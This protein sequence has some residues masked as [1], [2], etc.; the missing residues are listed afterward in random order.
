MRKLLFVCCTLIQIQLLAQPT[1][2]FYGIS[3]TTGLSSGS[4][5]AIVQDTTGFIW[6]GTKNGLNRYDG[7]R[8]VH[9]HSSNS[10]LKSN[11]ISALLNDHKGRLWVG[12]NGGGL[13]LSDSESQPLRPYLSGNPASSIGENIL[14]LYQHQPD[15]LWVISELGL[16]KIVIDGRS[17]QTKQILDNAQ[18]LN[19]ITSTD[20]GY[21]IGGNRGQILHYGLD[22]KN[23][24]SYIISEKS[25]SRN[26]VFKIIKLNDH[27]LLVGTEHDGLLVFD[28]PKKQFIKTE[29]QSTIV[30]DIL[31]DNDDVLWVATDGNGLYSG[32][33]INEFIQHKH[34][35]GTQ[36]SLI[37][38]AV[39]NLFEDRSNNLWIGTAWDGLSVIDTE[40]KQFGF[41][42]SD[43]VGAK[44][45][46]VLS[47]FTDNKN[48]ILGS[49]G[50]GITDLHVKL[51]SK[52]PSDAYVQKIKKMDDGFFWI[53]TFKNG[54]Y[55]INK[56]S[57][58][59]YHADQAGSKISHND[60][61]D[62]L[63]LT[64][65]TY[66]VATWGGGLNIFDLSINTFSTL[67]EWNQASLNPL[68]IVTME[69]DDTVIWI[70]TYGGGLYKFD[71]KSYRLESVLS[72]PKNIISL[73]AVDDKLWIGTWGKGL[74]RMDKDSDKLTQIESSDL[75]SHETVVSIVSG[76]NQSI[77]I[78]T[79]KGVFNIQSNLAINRLDQLNGE[80]HINA[81]ASNDQIFFGNTKGAVSFNESILESE[82]NEIETQL[83]DVKLFN[84]SVLNRSEL[85]S[86]EGLAL[87]HDQN[88][89]TFEYAALLY[90]TSSKLEYQ[91]KLAPT[92][93]EWIDVGQQRSTTIA[94]LNAGEYTF[95]V[96]SKVNPLSE[97]NLPF[98]IEKPWW[99]KWWTFAI[100]LILFTFFL[101]LFQRYTS[102]WE[103]LKGN[104]KIEKLT[105]EKELEIGKIKQQFFINISHEIRTPLTLIIGELELLAA[106]TTKD[107]SIVDVLNKVRSNA[108]HMTQLVNELL[109]F[110]KLD[111]EGLKLNV[112]EGNIVKFAKEVFLSFQ[113]KALSSGIAYD[114]VVSNEEIVLFFDRDQSEKILFNLLSNA[115]KYTPSGGEI[116][117]T[118]EENDKY[119]FIKIMDSGKGIPPEQLSSVFDRF[120][121]SENAQKKDGFGIGLSI[122]KDIVLLHGGEIELESE[123]GKGSE[124]TVKLQKGHGHFKSEYILSDFQDSE[125]LDQYG[126]NVLKEATV[127]INKEENLI[128]IVEDN[129]GIRE[130]IGKSLE[131]EFQV[132]LAGNGQEALDLIKKELPDII[133]TDVMMPVMDGV[134]FLTKVKS[135]RNTS[136]IPVIMLTARTGLIYK[137][138]GFDLGADDYITKPFNSL[139]LKTRVRNILKN[140]QR[141]TDRIRNEFFINPK[142]ISISSPDE[143]FLFDLTQIV[144]KELSNS[145][146][147]AEFISKELGMSHSVVYKKLKALTG[148][149]IVEFVR[150]YRLTQA[151]K[152][153]LEY[154]CSVAETA[155]KVGFSDRKYFSQIFKKKYFVT[156][157]EYAKGQKET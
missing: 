104:L 43:F 30:R 22:F 32:T 156:P 12:T 55:R 85:W 101:Y 66:L 126:E 24:E 48:L 146:L 57:V 141:L 58:F 33:S 39:Y 60:V 13:Y 23:Y 67:D 69:D 16:F 102:N 56:R 116:S 2:L 111:S 132:M 14:Q 78:A 46:G 17:F 15:E 9:Y 76:A 93:K 142:E 65:N 148:F 51:A 72:T 123:P 18:S 131:G 88:T 130:F 4:V 138:E 140:Q 133:I 97:V 8:F 122:V 150:D 109:D 47:I 90:P 84:E 80:Y 40:T 73:K 154:G 118:I 108:N 103:K 89:L 59:H 119:V 127:V 139:L 128:L 106:K 64:K 92:N 7:L 113:N 120:Y 99:R 95:K 70:G 53:G 42:Y 44:S 62:I 110:R 29:I 121:Q 71:K 114:F 125:E 11:D 94:N 28:I 63:P 6:I 153:L 25:S 105:R 98:T 79:K 27:S 149:K 19:Y 21:W 87:S 35:P 26:T 124:F 61:R 107:K 151:G 52:L 135:D 31:I 74:F 143:K 41:Y 147:G 91:I 3:T 34:I 155:Y 68:E 100:V 37:S 1:K 81:S 96:R 77:W 38:N 5:T 129:V 86:S 115:F 36:S 45:T 20:S 83:L 137:K 145:E 157:T 82:T 75:Q 10:A 49:D 50:N 144:D 112:A 134:T 136:H 54:L 117:L 152:L